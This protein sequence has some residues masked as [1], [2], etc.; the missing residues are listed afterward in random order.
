MATTSRA[1][2]CRHGA[3]GHETNVPARFHRQHSREAFST[4]QRLGRQNGPI[5]PVLAGSQRRLRVDGSIG[6]D[7][8]VQR[9]REL[10]TSY[11]EPHPSTESYSFCYVRRVRRSEQLKSEEDFQI[12][13]GCNREGRYTPHSIVGQRSRDENQ[14]SSSKP[15]TCEPIQLMPRSPNSPPARKP[16]NAMTPTNI[17]PATPRRMSHGL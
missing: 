9:G 10:R 6:P 17:R 12:F 13:R 16:T 7:T 11:P 8:G 4:L 14:S 1:G 5:I 2:W 15:R 3:R